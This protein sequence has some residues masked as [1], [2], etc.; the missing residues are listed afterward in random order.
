MVGADE[1]TTVFVVPRRHPRPKPARPALLRIDPGHSPRRKAAC[2][3]KERYAS[4]AE[5]RSYALMHAPVRGRP[6]RVYA[7]D[8]CG[9]WHFTS[10]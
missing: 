8:I 6:T 9:G 4:E 5:A 2:E 7:C 10:S 3:G 1:I